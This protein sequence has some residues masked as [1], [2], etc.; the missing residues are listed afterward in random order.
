MCTKPCR[1]G[2]TREHTFIK[3]HSYKFG[4]QSTS[5]RPQSTV[6]VAGFKRRDA[7][8]L[9][10][11]CLACAASRI[12]PCQVVCR[13]LR[14]RR[15][16]G[17]GRVLSE[18]CVFKPGADKTSALSCLPAAARTQSPWPSPAPA[19][20]R[21]GAAIKGKRWSLLCG[22]GKETYIDFSN[23]PEKEGNLALPL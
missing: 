21:P 15:R 10:T 3:R 23:R 20:P 6:H 17:G 13:Q 19:T 14:T 7:G 11:M 12:P 9:S 5:R 4:I 8:A 18:S 16:R 1:W 22:H 2:W